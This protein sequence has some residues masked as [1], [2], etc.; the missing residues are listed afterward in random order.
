MKLVI[1]KIAVPTVLN[2]SEELDRIFFEYLEE[3]SISHKV[4][5]DDKTLD[6]S[7][8][9]LEGYPLVEYVGGVVS[10][11]NMLKERF[12]YTTEDIKEN[13]PELLEE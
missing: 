6:Y 10:L 11:T 8:F 7:Q 5:D 13:Y 1:K 3:Y 9:V 12:G 4:L 2:E